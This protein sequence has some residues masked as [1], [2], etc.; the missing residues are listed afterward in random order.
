MPVFRIIGRILPETFKLDLEPFELPATNQPVGLKGTIV[1][2]AKGNQFTAVCNFE[3]FD[4]T[5]HWFPLYT[6]V[7]DLLRTFLD[8]ITY[9]QGI[10]LTLIFDKVEHSDGTSGTILVRDESVMQ[11][12][13]ALSSPDDF[14]K[15][16]TLLVDDDEMQLALRDLSDSVSSLYSA[17]ISCARAIEAIRNKFIPPGGRKD[18]GWKPMHAALNVTQKFL[19]D[20]TDISRDPRHGR[21]RKISGVGDSARLV[22]YRSWAVMNRYLEYM[23]RDYKPLPLSEFPLL[24]AD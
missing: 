21:S 6:R 24:D 2:E 18:D 15:I 3:S 9:Q 8:L 17:P 23:K 14:S 10:P 19:K 11:Y 22:G 12:V 7:H 1:L 13:T 16:F 20:I 4:K 5:R